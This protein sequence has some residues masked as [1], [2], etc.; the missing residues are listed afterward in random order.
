MA[1][2]EKSIDKGNIILLLSALLIIVLL[3]EGLLYL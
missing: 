2:K 1:Q 3:A